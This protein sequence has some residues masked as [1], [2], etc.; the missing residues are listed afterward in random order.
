MSPR[1]TATPAAAR[2]IERLTERYGPLM[3]VQSGG[4]CDGSSP[5]CFL[6]GTFVI[7]PNDRFLGKVAGARFY[8]DE[9]QDERWHRPQLEL[10]VAEGAA[11]GFSLEALDGIHFVNRSSP[12]RVFP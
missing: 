2:A 11:E 8:I 12:S 10:D 5:I 6:S 9:E 4:C 1:V 7:G 3:F